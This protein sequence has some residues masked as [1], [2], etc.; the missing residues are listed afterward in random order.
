MAEPTSVKNIID[1]VLRRSGELTD[2]TSDYN[3]DALEYVNKVYR[4]VLSGSNEYD[5]DINEDWGWAKSQY[6][7]VITLEPKYNTGSVSLTQG[8]T[9]GTFSSPP[10]DSKA[11]W[12]LKLD[13]RPEYFR[14]SSH[15]AA[16]AGF[17]LDG[18]YTGETGASLGY[19]VVKI[20]YVLDPGNDEK[21]LR[22][23]APFEIYKTQDFTGDD[24]GKVYS[25]S[26]NEFKKLYPLKDL[27][28]DIPTHFTEI[29]DNNGIKT[30]RFNKY[31]NEKTRVE[32]EYIPE[33]VKLKD[34]GGSLP[35]IPIDFRDALIYGAIYH[36]LLDKSDN[37]AANFLELLQQKLRA[38]IKDHRR[39]KS[40][41]AKRKGALVPRQE[42][43]IR[44]V[45]RIRYY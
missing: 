21:I 19:K 32:Y 4:D 13:S 17:V 34:S 7:K 36:I 6:P 43:I 30:V 8:S 27:E 11:N 2:G 39:E 41:G 23:I 45:D 3:E 20:D 22:L 12:W 14:L 31:A 29:L 28:E 9:A 40:Y 35:L 16:A 5:V 24:E 10:S 15:T 44:R 38:M 26:F 42:Q 33:P 18:E 25:L 37:K 1:T